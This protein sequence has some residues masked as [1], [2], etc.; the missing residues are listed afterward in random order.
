[1]QSFHQ[2]AGILSDYFK[3]LFELWLTK[4]NKIEK[5]IHVSMT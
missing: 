5:Y 3:L 4:L 1:M 2:D